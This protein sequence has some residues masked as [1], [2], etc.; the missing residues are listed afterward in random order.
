MKEIKYINNYKIISYNS[1]NIYI[2]ENI[3]DDSFCKEMINIINTL[4][5][6]KIIIGPRQNVQCYSTILNHIIEKNDETYYMFNNKNYNEI[7]YSNIHNGIR[8][9]EL[10][11]YKN[12]INEKMKI[13]NSLIKFFNKNIMLDFHCGYNLRK[14]YGETKRHIDG[15]D[16]VF[17]ERDKVYSINNEEQ[18]T[19]FNMARNATIIF[20]LND[21]YEGGEFNFPNQEIKIRLSK[22]SAIIFPPF[23]TNCHY[24]S[25]LENNT[26]RYT[27]N[28]WS[29]ENIDR[30]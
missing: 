5:L 7:K 2:I 16:K 23:W 8:N 19:K 25:K 27:I 10:V 30:N 3:L 26:Y 15:L 17:T 28:T 12:I 14:I 24:V 6:S 1:S 29:L 11:N 22:G 13:I 9:N 20:A 4:P 21:N 18:D